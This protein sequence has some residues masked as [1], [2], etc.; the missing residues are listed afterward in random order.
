MAQLMPMMKR[1]SVSSRQ[2]GIANHVS[3]RQRSLFQLRSSLYIRLTVQEAKTHA[4]RGVG[5]KTQSPSPAMAMVFGC[6]T[7]AGIKEGRD[8]GCSTTY[9]LYAARASL[10]PLPESH[11]GIDPVGITAP[12]SD[13]RQKAAQPIKRR[14]R[15]PAL[16]AAVHQKTIFRFVRLISKPPPTDTDRDYLALPTMPFAG[17]T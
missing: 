4:S 14:N 13:L 17:F 5:D 9:Q 6:R 2:D 15:H 8:T 12:A 7:R 10:L 3:V 11:C 16:P 1:G